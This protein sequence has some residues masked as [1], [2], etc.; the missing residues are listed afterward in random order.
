MSYFREEM[1]SLIC[2]TKLSYGDLLL[3]E[4]YL[5]VAEY[6]RIV[7]LIQE[8]LHDIKSFLKLKDGLILKQIFTKF[9]T[10]PICNQ[11]TYMKLKKMLNDILKIHQKKDQHFYLLCW[12][13]Y[14]KGTTDV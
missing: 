11:M 9:V 5:I 4:Q 1:M 10:L 12:I 14:C 13:D 2:K 6:S 7:N 8:L 3:K